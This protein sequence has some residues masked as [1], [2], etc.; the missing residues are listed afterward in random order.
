MCIRDRLR[1]VLKRI[2]WKLQTLRPAARLKHPAR[3]Q[4]R[5]MYP[6]RESPS[7]TFTSVSN[8]SR[9][10]LDQTP[11]LLFT[12][13]ETQYL[14]AFKPPRTSSG[15]FQRV[16]IIGFRNNYATFKQIRTET[17]TVEGDAKK[18]KLFI[19]L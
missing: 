17:I 13:S 9:R 18:A 8:S 5:S 19:T 11:P 10:M 16:I 6:T 15:K 14:L 1:R 4:N 12:L 7:S 2:E 3:T